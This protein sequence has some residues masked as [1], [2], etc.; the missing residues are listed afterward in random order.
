M[1]AGNLLEQRNPFPLINA[2]RKFLEFNPEAKNDSQLL[3][4]GPAQFHEHELKLLQNEIPTLVA[5]CRNFPL[6]KF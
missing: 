2:Y 4:V 3:F 6:L 5:A 1:H